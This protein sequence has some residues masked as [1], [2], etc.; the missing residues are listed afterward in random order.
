MLSTPC[1]LHHRPECWGVRGIR[2]RPQVILRQIDPRNGDSNDLS[3]EIVDSIKALDDAHW[4]VVIDAM[5]NVVHGARGTAR[6]VGVGT[7]YRI[8]G[9]TGTAQVF[10]IGQDE[11]YEEDKVDRYLRDHGCSLPSPPRRD[12]DSRSRS[13]SRTAARVAVRPRPSRGRCSTSICNRK[14]IH[15][16][17]TECSSP[18]SPTE[19]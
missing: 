9:K 4:D 17:K 10:A 12:H 13:W 11:K 8:A 7:T 16:T 5:E 6:R 19:L 2:M 1:S 18:R 14:M 3:P 15:W